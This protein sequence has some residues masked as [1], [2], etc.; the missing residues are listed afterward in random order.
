MNYSNLIISIFLISSRPIAGASAQVNIGN[1]VVGGHPMRGAHSI[2][3]ETNN[4]QR[5]ISSVANGRAVGSTTIERTNDLPDRLLC[6]V[7]GFGICALLMG[8]DSVR[9]WALAAILFPETSTR[10]LWRT[11]LCVLS[12]VL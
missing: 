7:Q 4:G 10:L 9:P 12:R 3:V 6:A 5:V 8:D 11:G 2:A 1:V